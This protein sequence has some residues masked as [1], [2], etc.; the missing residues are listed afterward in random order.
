VLL[1]QRRQLCREARGRRPDRRVRQQAA[2]TEG[3]LADGQ[4]DAGLVLEVRDRQPRAERLPRGTEAAVGVRADGCDQSLR[5]G[6][7]GHRPGG[8]R[9]QLV[10][11]ARPAEPAEQRHRQRR[12]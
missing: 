7:A 5:V 8:S 4:A 12:C 9:R 2:P 6:E 3:F 11:E 10:D 1:K